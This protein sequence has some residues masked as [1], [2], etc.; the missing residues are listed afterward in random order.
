[1]R[2]RKNL[3]GFGRQKTR[4]WTVKK[5]PW[6]YTVLHGSKPIDEFKTKRE[7]DDFVKWAREKDRT[8]KANPRRKTRRVKQTTRRVKRN[9]AR[10]RRRK[11]ARRRNRKIT[12]PVPVTPQQRKKLSRWLKTNFGKRIRV[13]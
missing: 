4:R 7:A 13:K 12:F 10:T 9:S 6:G 1:M 11:T 3:F 8:M 5:Q 2:K